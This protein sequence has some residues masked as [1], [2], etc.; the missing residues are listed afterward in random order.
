MSAT[1]GTFNFG[2]L[3][4]G[5]VAV[6]LSVSMVLLIL[7]RLLRGQ[8][9]VAAVSHSPV[10]WTGTDVC[11]AFMIMIGMQLGG[12]VLIRSFVGP[13]I[14]TRPVDL[15]A[16]ICSTVCAVVCTIGFF[17][18]R[19]ATLSMLG[20][21]L[22]HCRQDAWRAIAGLALVVAPLLTLAGVLDSIVPYHHPIIDF[23]KAHQDATVTAMI[24]LS[25]VVVVPI[26]EE[27]LFRRILQ[28]WLETRE[29]Q[30]SGWEGPLPMTSYSK[31]WG[32]IAVASLCFGLAHYGQ[33]AAWIPLTLFGMVLGWSVSQTGRLF[34]AILLHGAFNCVSVVIC[35]L[36]N[37]QAS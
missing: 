35:L 8:N 37:N 1:E 15:A 32:S 31:G 4:V 11:V 2:T 21:S 24:V 27:L 18:K 5:T 19:G 34:S 3:L 9:V 14:E 22:L 6:S 28:G 17:L 33:G 20:L 30:R 26:A 16:S 36:Q 13:S 25:A 23:L 10:S 7:K 29:A 12:V